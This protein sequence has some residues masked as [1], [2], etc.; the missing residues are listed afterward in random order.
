LK[1]LSK[2][3]TLERRISTLVNDLIEAHYLISE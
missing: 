2:T 3:H 1:R